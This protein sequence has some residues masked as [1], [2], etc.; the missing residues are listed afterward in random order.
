MTYTVESDVLWSQYGKGLR[1]LEENR[2]LSV[3][4]AEHM[5]QKK[6][7]E[8]HREY[9]DALETLT[10]AEKMSTTTRVESE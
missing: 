8:L 4:Y 9:L 6:S 10:E 7:D 1:E 2:D 5:F 3:A